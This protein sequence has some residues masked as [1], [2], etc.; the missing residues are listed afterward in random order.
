M[1][2][3]STFAL[4]AA[5]L[6]SLVSAAPVAPI[7][8][9]VGRAPSCSLTGAKPNLTGTTITV[10]A[11]T[12]VNVAL[13]VGTQNYTCGAAGTFTS[14]GAVATLFDVSCLAKTGPLIDNLPNMAFAVA[15]NEKGAALIGKLGPVIQSSP[16]VLAH[17]YFITNP[18]PG[19][20]GITPVFDARADSKKGDPTAFVAVKKV[21]NSPAPTD[22]AHNVD[23][24]SLQNIGGTIGG[25]MAN[26]VLRVATKN[27]QPPTSCSGNATVQVP[28]TAL[29]WFYK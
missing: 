12:L 28:Y 16:F 25:S 23:F 15:S 29:Y 21:A 14:A 19:A 18:A 8:P 5:S 13:G 17:H 26:N 6:S 24:L 2:F 22:S 7:N 27:G 10:P 20:T 11:G 9:A 1:M 3:F 4:F